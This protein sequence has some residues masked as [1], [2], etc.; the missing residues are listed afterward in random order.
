MLTQP[1]IRL[2]GEAVARYFGAAPA[3]EAILHPDSFLALSGEPVAD[4]NLGFIDEGPHALDRLHQ[5]GGRVRRLGLPCM[6][7]L[8]NDASERLAPTAKEFGLGHVGSV[9]L[10]IL[11][12]SHELPTSAD[13]AVEQVSDD[14]GRVNAAALVAR[15][16]DI[17][18]ASMNRVLGPAILDEPD[19]KLYVARRDAVPISTVS[20]TRAGDTVGIWSMGTPPEFQRQGAGAATLASVINAQRR[21]GAK[22]FYLY[23]S[24]QGQPLYRKLGFQT[25]TTL[26]AWV[27]GHSTQAAG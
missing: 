3:F 8:T 2:S 26:A 20:T 6:L 4:L 27:R 21:Q 12:P 19:V 1:L 5:Y 10:M 9:P 22:R 16:F 17:P 25:L 13:F 15:A 24:D 14:G 23:A 7:L 11:E 18:L